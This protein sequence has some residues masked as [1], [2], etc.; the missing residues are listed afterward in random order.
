A[1]NNFFRLNALAE[2]M[3]KILPFND[4]VTGNYY[5]NDGGGFSLQSLFILGEYAVMVLFRHIFWC[6]GVLNLAMI[7]FVLAKL[8]FSKLND[9]KKLCFT[10]PLFC[11]NFGTMLLL[12]S[13]DFRYFYYSYLVF[14]LMLLMLIK[15]DK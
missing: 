9:W 12:K 6:I 7:I 2:L 1:N 15:S 13:N 4:S 10:L 14:P 11:Y 5:M 8:D 3:E